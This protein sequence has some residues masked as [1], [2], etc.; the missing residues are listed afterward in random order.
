MLENSCSLLDIF[1]NVLPKGMEEMF[2]MAFLLIMCY[3]CCSKK[4]RE[5]KKKKKKTKCVC[6]RENEGS[7]LSSLET[8]VNFHCSAQQS[9]SLMFFSF[10]VSKFGSKKEGKRRGR[11]LHPLYSVFIAFLHFK[12][13]KSIYP[14]NPRTC[15]VCEG[16]AIKPVQLYNLF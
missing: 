4:G 6:A 5:R 2:K 11:K 16:T 12:S 7:P 14:Q 1:E 8:D 13:P 15:F 9:A 10:C 3:S